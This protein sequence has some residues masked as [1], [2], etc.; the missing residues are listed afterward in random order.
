MPIIH[1]AM[2]DLRF[3]GDDALTIGMSGISVVSEDK[4]TLI[5]V[6]KCIF[7]SWRLPTKSAKTCELVWCSVLQLSSCWLEFE[8]FWLILFLP[9]PTAVAKVVLNSVGGGEDLPKEDYITI[10]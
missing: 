4:F 10:M 8:I 2:K 6:S 5:S 9:F 7:S 3:I 1:T